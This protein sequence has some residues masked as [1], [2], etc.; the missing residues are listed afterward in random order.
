MAA[1]DSSDGTRSRLSQGRAGRLCLVLPLCSDYGAAIS[2]GTG[3]VTLPVEAHSAPRVNVTLKVGSADVSPSWPKAV[4]KTRPLPYSVVH[5]I[6]SLIPG[7]DM[8]CLL[9]ASEAL[10]SY[11]EWSSYAVGQHVIAPLGLPLQ[12]GA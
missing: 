1:L 4:M 12:V 11:K 2:G 3:S 5:N 7:P 6:G 8:G 9:R 10:S